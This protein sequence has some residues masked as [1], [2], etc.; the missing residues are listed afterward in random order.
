MATR[1]PAT[2]WRNLWR[3]RRRTLITCSSI[4]F[5]ILFATVLTGIGDATYSEMIDLAARMGNGHV[6]IQH[7]EYL[8]TPTL[9]RSVT[10][11]DGLLGLALGDPEVER[12]VQRISGNVMLA[13][14]SKSTGAG[15]IAFD[16]AVEDTA[17][18]SLLDSVVEG[19]LFAENGRA[20]I[21]V[22][23]D[24]AR[25]LGGGI[26]RRVILTFTDKDGEIVQEAVRI[27]GLLRTGAP[28]P[29]AGLVLLPIS[30][31]QETLGYGQDETSQVAVFVGDQ[32]ASETVA[33]R[34]DR[35]LGPG[36]RA[37]PW[38]EVKPD[39]AGFIAMKL[40]STII[41]ELLIL[42]LVGAGIFNTLF[43][44][45]MERLR[46][47]GVLLALGFTPRRLFSLVMWESLWLALVGCV[48][49]VLLTAGPYLYLSRVGIDL[50]GFVDA[51]AAE[52]S[53]VTVGMV[54]RS[55]I[56]PENAVL[57]MLAAIGATLLAG[58]Y[59]A[60]RAGRVDPVESIRLV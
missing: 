19:S 6:A 8:D 31:M 43:M 9:S 39:L 58:V 46:E 26:G 29:D 11:A 17:T 42:V 35:Q 60:W 37:I 45:V 33:A 18:L 36:A 34:L 56:Y 15:F 41:T 7:P 55:E 21:I 40:G 38:N 10:G 14:A 2:A 4:A 23:V 25:S 53:G 27:T 30:L 1:V 5:A 54:L 48:A 12:A 47:F 49:G 22:G 59:P 51:E 13:S 28:T 3:Q 50:R 32:R 20:G 44:S 16:P 52:I 57:I 24:L